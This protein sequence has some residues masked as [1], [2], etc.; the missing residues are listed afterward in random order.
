MPAGGYS[1]DPSAQSQIGN[2]KSKMS[3]ATIR[4]LNWHE[5][6]S[7][8]SGLRASVYEALRMHGP[9]TTRQL[10]AKAGLDI[11]TVRPRVTELC[12][13]GFASLVDHSPHPSSISSAEG[14]Y[15]AH[16]FAEAAAHHAREQALARG[17]GVQ[18]T[19]FDLSR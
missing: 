3:P 16:T 2:P 5:L 11:L 4:D 8:L 9:C 10:A 17:E 7:R 6:Q 1:F 12:Q 15:R 19:L 18:E 14:L 13:L